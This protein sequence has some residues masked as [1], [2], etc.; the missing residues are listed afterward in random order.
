MRILVHEF[1]SGGGFVRRPVP[2]SLL[3]E[4]RAMR[5]ALVDDLVAIGR[6]EIVATVDARFPLASRRGVEAAR[7]SASAPSALAPLIASVDAVWLVAPETD[8]CLERLASQVER[9]GKRLLG[10]SAAAIRAVTDKAALPRWLRRANVAHPVTRV[11]RTITRCRQLAREI[12]YPL[13]VKPARGAGCAGVSLVRSER[14]LSQAVCAV[15]R[16]QPGARIVMQPY[17]EGLSASVSLLID[18]NRTRALTLNA[19]RVRAAR[20]FSYH[21]GRTPLRHPLM[22]EAIDV[23][24]GACEAFVGLRGYVGVDL[25]LTKSRAFVIEINP[26]L[27]TAYLGVRAALDENVAALALGACSGRL[28]QQP[29]FPTR[30]VRFSASGRIRL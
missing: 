26:R 9:Q 7:L 3:Q 23:A 16:S 12:G 4:G 14:E 27:T 21:G 8:R 29:A 15:R 18:G 2:P 28:P 22:D 10:S 19:Q 1:V 13:V 5:D 24:R 20:P 6:H 25:V 11:S 30:A 17:L